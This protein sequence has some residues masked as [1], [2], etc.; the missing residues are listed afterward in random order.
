MWS[1][2]VLDVAIGL[3]FVFLLVSVLCA[4]IREGLEAWM[5]TR[6]SYLE[7]GIFQMLNDKALVKSVYEHPLVFGLYEGEY[8]TSMA[9]DAT[10][11]VGGNLPSYIPAASFARALMDVVARGPVPVKGGSGPVASPADLSK[12]LG[13]EE[14]R[15]RVLALPD[16]RLKRTLLIAVDAAGNRM[17]GVQTELEQWFDSTMDRVSGWYKRNSAVMLFFIGLIVASCG[18]ID[19]IGIANHLYANGPARERLLKEAELMVQ[20]PGKAV[21]VGN[22]LPEVPSGTT[23]DAKGSGTTGGS[24]SASRRTEVRSGSGDASKGSAEREMKPQGGAE[25]SKSE[26]RGGAGGQI[27]ANNKK[28]PAVDAGKGGVRSG[29]AGEGA[30]ERVEAGGKDVFKRLE[31]LALPIGWGAISLPWW[32]HLPGWLITA[33]AVML[34]APFWFDVLSRIMVVRSTVKPKE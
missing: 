34:G 33:I 20:S 23:V 6:A 25:G 4:S 11:L 29:T 12:A 7:Q 10:G 21:A 2:T 14:L 15:G 32:E 30:V 17:E 19:T 26:T 28:S 9:T 13:I 27:V 22:T 3:I 5:K 1:S 18:N 8:N 16:E 24:D 31:S